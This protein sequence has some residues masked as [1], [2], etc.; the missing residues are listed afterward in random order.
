MK[1]MISLFPLATLFFSLL[2]LQASEAQEQDLLGNQATWKDLAWDN[3]EFNIQQFSVRPEPFSGLL[4][5]R[6]YQNQIARVFWEGLDV[7]DEVASTV[8]T[9]PELFERL[10]LQLDQVPFSFDVNYDALYGYPSKVAINPVQEVVDEELNISVSN[11]MRLSQLDEL[12]ANQQLWNSYGILDYL[13]RFTLAFGNVED[14]LI[15]VESEQVVLVTDFFE[16]AAP[17]TFAALT[18]PEL[19]ASLADRMLEGEGFNSINYHDTYG[20]PQVLGDDNNARIEFLTP[21]TV[22]S[23]DLADARSLWNTR[24]VMVYSFKLQLS[25]NRPGEYN[26]PHIIQVNDGTVI[27]V[28]DEETGLEPSFQFINLETQNVESFFLDIQNALDAKRPQIVVEYDKVYG[29]PTDIFIDRVVAIVDEEYYAYLSNL[30][31]VDDE[32][33]EFD[34]LTITPESSSPSTSPS[35]APT[36]E[37]SSSPSESLQPTATPSLEPTATLSLEPTATLSLEPSKEPT[38]SPVADSLAPSVVSPAGVSGTSIGLQTA[39]DSGA[40]M[41]TGSVGYAVLSMALVAMI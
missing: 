8:P 29:Y 31:Q 22:L 5:V 7:T 41:A 26:R 14:N 39:D 11:V 28:T 24:D 20:Y 16:D 12:Q 30:V 40:S 10:Q 27:S 34:S 36:K 2:L 35:L 21:Y 17:A 33:R 9:L 18:I 1:I 4:L 6:V 23:Q 25:S 37:A 38:P 32:L 15:H 3:Y 19:F 13:Y